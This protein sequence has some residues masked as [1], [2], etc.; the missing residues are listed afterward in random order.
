MTSE[1]RHE[2]RNRPNWLP[3]VHLGKFVKWLL[4]IIGITYLID[5]IIKRRPVRAA[6]DGIQAWTNIIVVW[7]L[8]LWIG[9]FILSIELII[10]WNHIS[11]VYN[12]DSGQW[13]VLVASACSLVRALWI[14]QKLEF[15][16]KDE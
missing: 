13:I 3:Q 4:N 14:W 11:G 16:P 5:Q 12:F 15:K 1:E 8:I 10:P 9:L 2:N 7:L 6:A